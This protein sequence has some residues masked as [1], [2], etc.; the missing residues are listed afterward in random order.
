MA[1]RMRLAVVSDVHA[2]LTALEAVVADLKRA[3][4]DL[5]VHGGDLVGS[6]ARPS[7]VVDTVRELGW[8]GVQGN[9]E[10]MLWDRPKVEAYF[11]PPALQRWRD[12]VG[13]TIATTVQAIGAERLAWLRALPA[14]RVE[15]NVTLL[16]ASPHDLW[17]S[18]MANAADDEL[19]R[20][21]GELGTSL[22]IYG[23][24]HCPYV[25]RLPSLTIANS[26]SVGMP[27][28]GDPRASYLIVDDDQVTVRRV[29]YD[30][31]HEVE[32]LFETR[33]PDAE[34]LADV[35]RQGRP[36]PLPL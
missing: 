12:V 8:P 4:P 15:G 5:V 35:L 10:E 6:G 31:D 32:S 17:R 24:V 19:A 26:G 3:S 34:W 7:E 27:Y 28:D 13:R 21:Y 29:E 22:V 14:V 16:H 20:C 23:H 1:D 36:L 33:S 30:I 11:E 2:N 25:R 18:P 9:A